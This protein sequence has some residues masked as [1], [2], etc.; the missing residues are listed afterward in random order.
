MVYLIDTNV[1][2]VANDP[3]HPAGLD[4]VESCVD[5]LIAHQSRRYAVDDLFR[6]FDEYMRYASMSGKPNVGDEF[7]K[8]LWDNQ[9][10]PEVCQQIQLHETGRDDVLFQILTDIPGIEKFDRA[11]QKFLA[12]ALHLS[13][14][15]TIVN[16]TDS[17]WSE[18]TDI[19]AEQRV[20]LLQLCLSSK[21]M[22]YR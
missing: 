12:V 1:L 9:A 15:V 14:E 13:G 5:F 22:F 17:D 10:N 19:L 20:E 6:I 16:A 2:A 21:Q 11:D 3:D 4:C 18:I 7:L 8:W